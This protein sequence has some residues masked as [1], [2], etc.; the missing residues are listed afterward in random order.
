[1]DLERESEGEVGLEFAVVVHAVLPGT[2]TSASLD[3][4]IRV[5]ELGRKTP[6]AAIGLIAEP[7]Y[8]GD[9]WSK[10]VATLARRANGNRVFEILCMIHNATAGEGDVR[11]LPH[12][13]LGWAI[14]LAVQQ[15]D[16][17]EAKIA[18]RS[19]VTI[20]E[21]V[22][23]LKDDDVDTPIGAM[24][25][26]G[27]RTCAEHPDAR[28]RVSVAWGLARMVHVCATQQVRQV[29]VEL[30]GIAGDAHGKGLANDHSGMV[31]VLVQ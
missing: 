6:T 19:V 23:L 10:L 28:V 29:A 21:L 4:L 15:I 20:V 17:R 8:W 25:L 3:W 12:S 9:C 7:K 11:R 16:N 30:V 26:A 27:L 2:G 5:L 18:N 13:D 31:R 22:P 24:L 14:P 1:L